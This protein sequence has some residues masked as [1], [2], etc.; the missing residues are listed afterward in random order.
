MR[1][2]FVDEY[3]HDGAF[4]EG[5]ARLSFAR[6]LERTLLKRSDAVVVVSEAFR[7][8]LL[9]REDLS[10][11]V[12]AERIHVI[13][14]RVDMARF[15]A[16]L[17]RREELRERR[18]WSDSIVAVFVGSTAAWHR[19]DSTMEIMAR[20]MSELPAV[21]LA[22]A[23]YPTT[24]EA[25]ELASRYSI[26]P[27]RLDI[28]TVPVADIPTLLASADLGLMFIEY[29]VSKSVCAP[30]K[31]GEYLAA[32]LPTVSS[33]HVGDT[34]SWIEREQL[35][36]VADHGAPAEAASRIV[37]FLTSDDF[38]DGTARERCLRFARR[39]LDMSETLRQYEDIYRELE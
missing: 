17:A 32:G 2:L 22:V 30:I 7:Q 6:R 33:P 11:L 5:T 8:H 24:T 14:N 37:E 26:P 38:R 23:V 12:G 35:G 15:E 18:G 29:H 34:Q 10:G 19:L 27:E 28:A 36:V 39:E 4:R 31:F 16:V 21:R 25:R 9:E 13:P 20:V 3:L 1:G